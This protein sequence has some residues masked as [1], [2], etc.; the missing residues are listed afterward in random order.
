MKP[1]LIPF[2]AALVAFG[3]QAAGDKLKLGSFG[4]GKPSGPLLT[5]TE[6][7]DCLERLDRIRSRNDAL[8]Q[9]RERI[10]RDKADLLKL[11]DDLKAQLETLD[12]TNAEAVEAFKARAS[13]REQAIDGFEKR[14][15]AFNG[16]IE[17]LGGE[18]KQFAQRC[19]NRRFDELDETA[20]RAGK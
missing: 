6:L 14:T 3:T 15:V 11:G 8:A 20:I 16:D 9:E 12:R 4:P 13:A 1:V 7:R 2:C 5:R 17:A 18:R 10:E 19:E